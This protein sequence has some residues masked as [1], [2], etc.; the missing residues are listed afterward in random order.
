MWRT[1]CPYGL[2]I[3]EFGLH[4]DRYAYG[5]G[6][7]VLDC[8]VGVLDYAVVVGFLGPFVDYGAGED[9]G[10]VGGEDGWHV[11]ECTWTGGDTAVFG[12]EHWDGVAL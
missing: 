7:V 4:G 5:H 9:G 11:G 10:H 1:Y 3:I 2:E 8:C 12:E 6:D